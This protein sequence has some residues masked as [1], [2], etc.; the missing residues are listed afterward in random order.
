MSSNSRRWTRVPAILTAVAGVVAI[1]T[2]LFLTGGRKG[3]VVNVDGYW[4]GQLPSKWEIGHLGHVQM[5]VEDTHQYELDTDE[6]ADHWAK[7]APKNGVI[8]LDNNSTATISMFHQLRCLNVLRV[9]LVQASRTKAPPGPRVRHCL[10]YIRQM[11]L[12]RSDLRLEN[13]R[14]P[15]IHAVDLT[16]LHTCQDWRKVYSAVEQNHASHAQSAP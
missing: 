5:S 10:N 3:G 13:V 16:S 2:V 11:I 6:G 1:M 7:L 9:A 12:C 15:V 8:H 14:D 4:E